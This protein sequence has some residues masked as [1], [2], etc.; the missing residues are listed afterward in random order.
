MS[1]QKTPVLEHTETCMPLSELRWRGG[2]LQQQWLVETRKR[3]GLA[4]P[5]VSM[6]HEW[7][8]VPEVPADAE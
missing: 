4:V 6:R 1:E 7:R 5:T 2:R 8:D 3:S